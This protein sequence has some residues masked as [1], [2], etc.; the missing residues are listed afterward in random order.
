M[1]WEVE[2]LPK[3]HDPEK[4]RVNEE[5]D[6]LTHGGGS[7]SVVELASRGFLLEGKFAK[8]EAQ[9]LANELLV[10]P[11]VE[12]GR[13][14]ELNAFD[15]AEPDLH[16]FATVLLKPGVMDPVAQSVEQAARD[17][18]LQLESVRTFR[19][20]YAR[21]VPESKV[22]DLLFRKVLANDAIEQA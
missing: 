6:L 17:L 3:S 16:A 19:R 22:R 14:G 5:L 8:A 11:I 13:V 10:D 12:T 1:L 21:N 7:T 2:I 4:A 15:R 9:R 18:G 20:Y